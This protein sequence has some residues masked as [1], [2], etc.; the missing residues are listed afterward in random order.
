M[1]ASGE[2]CAL[3]CE[4]EVKDILFSERKRCEAVILNGCNEWNF[5]KMAIF[6]VNS[7]DNLDIGTL[8]F[9]EVRTIIIVEVNC[10][11]ETIAKEGCTVR[12][13]S[14]GVEEMRWKF[15]DE[16][17]AKSSIRDEVSSRGM[18]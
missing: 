9:C 6:Q 3:L 11:S 1:H 15:E 4:K 17:L 13:T 18:D 14:V 16:I 12:D 2:A 7:F 10:S 8:R 5:A